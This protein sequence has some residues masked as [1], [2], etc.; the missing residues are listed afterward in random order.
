MYLFLKEKQKLVKWT[1][2]NTL[3]LLF[4][5]R[6]QKE[7]TQYWAKSKWPTHTQ[8]P[9]NSTKKRARAQETKIKKEIKKQRQTALGQAQILHNTHKQKTKTK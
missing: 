8:T 6:V 3:S 2:K 7:K 4:K 9:K 5:K 1:Q